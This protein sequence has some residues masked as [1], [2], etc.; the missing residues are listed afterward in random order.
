MPFPEHQDL[1]VKTREFVELIRSVS[2]PEDVMF[3]LT[4][5]SE[6]FEVVWNK[7]SAEDLKADGISMRNLKREFI[8]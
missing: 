2:D 8:Q 6:D 3:R 1:A 5:T 4:I 7:R